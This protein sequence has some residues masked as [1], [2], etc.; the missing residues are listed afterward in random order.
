MI[1]LAIPCPDKRE[2]LL[3]AQLPVTNYNL[4]AMEETQFLS[5]REEEGGGAAKRRAEG[6]SD[7]LGRKKWKADFK[8][9]TINTCR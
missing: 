5:G 2:T 4:P 6:E 1:F 7:T 3:P 8:K 9:R